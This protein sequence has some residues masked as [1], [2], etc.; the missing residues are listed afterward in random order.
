MDI[1]IFKVRMARKVLQQIRATQEKIRVLAAQRQTENSLV[2]LSSLSRGKLLIDTMQNDI[3]FKAASVQS[4]F[5]TTKE[6]TS[7][8]ASIQENLQATNNRKLSRHNT[9]KRLDTSSLSLS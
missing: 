8:F 4:P 2:P 3:Y 1:L 7:A 5:S 6:N 9:P